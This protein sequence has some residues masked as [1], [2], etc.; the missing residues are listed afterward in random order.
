MR[1]EKLPETLEYWTYLC[2]V[3]FPSLENI[4]RSEL[5]VEFGPTTRGFEVVPSRY[6][7]ILRYIHIRAY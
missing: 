4:R 7:D 5:V 2:I 6:P 1:I 3:T